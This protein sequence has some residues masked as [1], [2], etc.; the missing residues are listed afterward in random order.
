MNRLPLRC[1]LA[2][3]LGLA[4]LVPPFAA[5][6]ADGAAQQIAEDSW[7]YRVDVPGLY[8]DRAH[9]DLR[10][11][12]PARAAAD[13]RKAAAMIADEAKLASDGD[14]A[15]L[16]RDSRSLLQVADQV[17]AG[18]M[19]GARRL[20]LAV[21]TARA[22]LGAH[23]DLRAAEAWA[24]QDTQAAGRSLAAAARYTEGALATLDGRV[25]AGSARGLQAVE[26]FGEQLA[27]R[28]GSAVDTGWERARGAL[29]EALATLSR[30][31][32]VPPAG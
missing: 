3:T 2:A 30:K 18:R 21:V 14:Q 10:Q 15:R 20:D 32:A 1:L 22:D 13:L 17:D 23:Q 4:G 25:A 5:N 31:H 11:G 9:V 24:R 6:A 27:D 28:T 7:T 16:Q 12:Q 19:R 26:G 8:L 29:H